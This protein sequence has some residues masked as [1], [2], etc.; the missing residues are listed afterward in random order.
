MTQSRYILL[1]LVLLLAGGV[2]CSVLQTGVNNA[3]PDSGSVAAAASTGT[4]IPVSPPVTSTSTPTLTS[5]PITPSPTVTYVPQPATAPVSN[6][7]ATATIV[8]QIQASPTPAPPPPT[9]TPQPASSIKKGII[10]V[11]AYSVCDDVNRLNAAWYYRNNVSPSPDCP[12]P[13]SRYVPRL[14]NAKNIAPDVLAQAIESATASGWIIGFVEP[15]IPTWAGHV[16]P[17]EGA[18]AWRKVEEAV[19]PTG[20]KLVSPSPSQH[21]PGYFD[22]YGHTWLWEMVKAYQDEFGQKPHFDALAWN[23]YLKSV[24]A[25]RDY[26]VARH[27]EAVA[28]GYDVPFWILEYA[29][30]CWNTDQFPTGNDAIMTELTPLLEHTPWIQRYAWFAN[31]IKPDDIWA[32]NWHSCT[33]VN[34]DTNELTPLGQLYSAY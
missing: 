8:V 20:I 23:I 34:P 4:A 2:N 29:G 13:D 11:D 10:I 28:Q 12:V 30:E 7:T 27:Q 5:T 3:T 24:D 26:L 32:P 14:T 18:L 22:E 17:K 16:S 25:S 33:L 9:A 6:P 1:A 31:R 15:N 19:L 21:E